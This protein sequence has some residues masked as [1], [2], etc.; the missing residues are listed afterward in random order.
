MISV[1]RFIDGL[2]H[3]SKRLIGKATQPQGAGKGA[4]RAD[5]RI[6]TE[7]VG[8]ERTEL[9]GECHAALTMELGQGLVAQIVVSNAHPTLRPDGAGR[10]LDNL[11]D[12]TGLFRDRQGAADVPKSREKTGQTDE[13][14]QLAYT[15]L[16]SFRKR[17]S[18]LDCG[19]NLIG[20]TP[21]EHR[22]HRQDF[23]KN[24]LLV[25]CRGSRRR[26]RPAPVH[27]SPCFSRP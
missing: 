9:D 22:R 18:T 1:H 12:D 15:V 23:L 10:V 25:W 8:V 5:A 20:V 26:A 24:Q 11:R 6:K 13:K 27:T 17:K 21:G 16:E 3:D 14:A 7:E 4:E 2:L 19:A